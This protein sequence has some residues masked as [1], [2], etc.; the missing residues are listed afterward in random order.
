LNREVWPNNRS[1]FFAE[2]SFNTILL[3]SW[4]SRPSYEQFT[5]GTILRDF[6]VIPMSRKAIFNI[7]FPDANTSRRFTSMPNNVD[8]CGVADAIEFKSFK[9]TPSIFFAS[10]P[11]QIHVK[12]LACRALRGAL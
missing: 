11:I 12:L 1:A 6:R 2:I 10:N 7:A 9:A 3:A 8:T 4:N 5:F